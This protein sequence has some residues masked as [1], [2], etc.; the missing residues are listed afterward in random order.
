MP[1][2]FYN[3]GPYLIK[4]F[5]CNF[6]NIYVITPKKF[7][8]SDPQWPSSLK[9]EFEK[10]V[11]HFSHVY[12]LSKIM[13]LH[14]FVLLFLIIV[15]SCIVFDKEQK[16]SDFFC[17]KFQ[18]FFEQIFFFVKWNRVLFSS[19]FLILGTL[20]RNNDRPTHTHS[21]VTATPS[22]TLKMEFYEL[23]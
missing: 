11:V 7:Y 17:Q 21:R 10:Y 18:K 1:W 3:I 9:L 16:I 12:F 20:L 4:H 15:F 5:C 22:I 13:I 23:T 8:K 19:C 14:N 6:A 2:M